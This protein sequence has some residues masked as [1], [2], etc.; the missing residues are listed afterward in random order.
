MTLSLSIISQL[1]LPSHPS[2]S[3]GICSNQGD[4]LH[5]VH[6]NTCWLHPPD[7]TLR[8]SS[9]K[10]VERNAVLFSL[11]IWMLKSRLRYFAA[12][13]RASAKRKKESIKKPHLPVLW[14]VHVG[15]SFTLQLH[16][17]HWASI[18]LWPKIWL[19]LDGDYSAILPVSFV[20]SSTFLDTSLQTCA[21]PTLES[22]LSGQSFHIVHVH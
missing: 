5:L 22:T 4:P 11:Y 8:L 14:L 13:I 20:E 6:I 15:K 19:I 17:L 3:A 12:G 1:R 16:M 2:S 7:H 9:H 21:N 10:K 18:L